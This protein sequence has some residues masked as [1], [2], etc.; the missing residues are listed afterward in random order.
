M[1]QMGGYP[2]QMGQ[3]GGGYPGQMGQMGG[4][5]PGQMGQM[6][7]YPGQIG[8]MGQ[9]GQMGS[10]APGMRGSPPP[11]APLAV[12]S[13]KTDKTALAGGLGDMVG[14]INLNL[15]GAD[16]AASPSHLVPP[17]VNSMRGGPSLL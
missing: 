17:K 4:G 13:L 8:Q 15:G 10:F 3:M 1:G 16:Q 7:G 12:G 2:G 9:V 5:Y 11:P 14:L 6:G